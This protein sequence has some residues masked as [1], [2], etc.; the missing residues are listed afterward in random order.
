ME[1]FKILPW[2]VWVLISG[3]L[4]G[5]A[6]M[7]GKSQIHKITASQIGVLRDVT[8]WFLAVG[9]WLALGTGRFGWMSLIAL[10]NGA[11]VAVGVAL[12]F[13]AIRSSLSGSTI[14]GYLISQ[15]MLVV[16]SAIIF[17]EW[18]YFDPRTMQGV[19]NILALVLTMAAMAVYVKSLHLG[20]KWATLLFISAVINVVGNMLA[21]YFVSGKMDVWDYFFVEQTGLTLGGILILY[22]R[23][24]GLSVG[25]E[26]TKVGILQGIIAL[27]GPIIYLNVLALYPL[28]LSSLVRRIAAIAVTSI[29]GLLYY[30]ERDGMGYRSYVSL[31]VAMLAFVIVMLVN[32]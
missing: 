3:V 16:G 7:V 13:K 26:N 15:V 9:V 21:K 6:Q 18:I 14:F 29:S 11:M 19:G 8:G 23:K 10:F 2:Q 24:Q 4:T 30:R 31:I 5:L 28:S 27:L 12:Y 22:Q 32:R 25:W 1:I 17:S 20:R